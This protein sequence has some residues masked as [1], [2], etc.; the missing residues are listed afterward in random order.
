MF[1]CVCNTLGVPPLLQFYEKDCSSY[2]CWSF[3]FKLFI[4]SAYNSQFLCLLFMV[5][6][7]NQDIVRNFPKLLRGSEEQFKLLI[8]EEDSLLCGKLLQLLA[9]VG[10]FITMELRYDPYY[11][12]ILLK[13]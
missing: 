6:F 3:S 11:A 2:F 13:L 1:Y 12:P 4:V 8:L 9:K 7:L 10:P 5:I